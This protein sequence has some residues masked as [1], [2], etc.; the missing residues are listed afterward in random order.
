MDISF[1]VVT[2]SKGLGKLGGG[3]PISLFGVFGCMLYE[4]GG[5]TS[6]LEC[7]G[8]CSGSLTDSGRGGRCYS[9]VLVELQLKT[10][11]GSVSSMGA[12]LT[13]VRRV[14]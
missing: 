6:I 8:M 14:Q 10:S 5:D 4:S 9:S 11:N 2:L 12:N 7:A 13:L 3:D 1:P